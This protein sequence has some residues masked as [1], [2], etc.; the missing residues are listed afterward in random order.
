MR[1]RQAQTAPSGRLATPIVNSK[2]E[3]VFVFFNNIGANA[4]IQS[5]V[6]LSASVTANLGTGTSSTL[7]P[8]TRPI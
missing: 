1:L 4:V 5:D 7:A 3:K 6:T 2:T 8:A